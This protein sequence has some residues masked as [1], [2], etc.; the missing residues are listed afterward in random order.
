MFPFEGNPAKPGGGIHAAHG[1]VG[2]RSFERVWVDVENRAPPRV[3]HWPHCSP[4]KW[5]KSTNMSR[6]HQRHCSAAQCA[7]AQTGHTIN[8]SRTF[9]CM[10]THI[11]NHASCLKPMATTQGPRSLLNPYF[12]HKSAIEHIN[13]C[14]AGCH[15]KRSAEMPPKLSLCLCGNREVT[16][17]SSCACWS[18][19]GVSRL[20]SFGGTAST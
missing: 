14:P 20:M 2:S 8:A 19:S 5:I 18:L 9:F 4:V 7:R 17:L 1:A 16:A 11:S 13:D 10:G 3:N 15:L 6:N 12:R